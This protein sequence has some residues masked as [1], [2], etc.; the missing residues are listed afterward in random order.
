[1]ETSYLAEKA[2][3]HFLI[4][5]ALVVTL[6]GVLIA[7]VFGVNIFG[8]GVR[9]APG[10]A[11]EL[12]AGKS[13]IPANFKDVP[14]YKT[15]RISFDGKTF[16]PSEVNIKKGD[17]VVWKN[18]SQEPNWPASAFHPTH[19]VYPEKGGCPLIGGSSFDACHDLM[20]GERW[21][22]QF[23]FIGEWSYHDHDHPSVGGFV[24]VTE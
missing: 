1:M 6:S 16:S 5:L 4:A 12:D 11:G 9:Y 7:F 17:V 19:D 13:E 10:V 20:P 2:H 23:N 21:S 14:G 24:N 8:A 18:A 15:W 3:R 22:F